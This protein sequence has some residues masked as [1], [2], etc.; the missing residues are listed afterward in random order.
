MFHSKCCSLSVPG[1]FQF[2]FFSELKRLRHLVLAI[3]FLFALSCFIKKCCECV[4]QSS[5]YI[6]GQGESN[7]EL[8]NLEVS[9]IWLL[10]LREVVQGKV[11]SHRFI[12][13]IYQLYLS[14]NSS[15]NRNLIDKIQRLPRCICILSRKWKFWQH[16][17]I[18]AVVRC[19]CNF[20][21]SLCMVLLHC[22]TFIN[23][24]SPCNIMS[25]NH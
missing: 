11:N 23:V 21:L 17:I 2:S 7:M 13:Y 16:S 15:N 20:S 12:I 19:D 3:Q 14:Y 1:R 5:N 24:F 6:N 4:F 22:L 10:H 18:Q 25:F 9:A 8:D